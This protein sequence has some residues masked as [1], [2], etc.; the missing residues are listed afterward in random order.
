MNVILLTECVEYHTITLGEFDKDL[1]YLLDRT[2]YDYIS[3][4]QRR[5]DERLNLLLLIQ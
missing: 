5:M 2:E 1:D 3:A 4:K